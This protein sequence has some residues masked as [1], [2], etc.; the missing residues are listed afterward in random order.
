MRIDTIV[1]PYQYEGA[2]ALST[3]VFVSGQLR[4]TPS[5]GLQVRW[6][7]DDNRVGTGEQNRT[8]IVNPQI[9][10]VLAF[11]IGPLFRFAAATSVG[12][13][14]ATGSDSSDT[15]ARLL[16]RQA[17]LARS[18]MDNNAF[19][20]TH[21]GVPTGLS[22]AFIHRGVT[23]QVDG[24]IIASGRVKG[25]EGEDAVVNSTFGFFLGYMFVP[26]FSLGAELRYQYFLLPPA[27]VDE[28]PSARDNLTAGAGM[29]VEIE[30]SDSS[31]I[32]P[33][34][35]VSTG[36]AGHVEQQSFHM[37]QFDVPISF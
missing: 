32:R 18:A 8:G 25:S 36:L 23:A 29:R 13:P 3:V 24:T 2:S 27:F 4:L 5:F 22:L 15:D 6:G 35:C 16:Q 11:P 9:G 14:V 37:V 30:L 31:R 28:D 26:E 33:G 12:F 34:L 21:L 20:P 10:A 17:A 7:F 1:A 19:I